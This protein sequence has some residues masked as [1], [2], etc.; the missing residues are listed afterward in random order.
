MIPLLTVRQPM[1]IT[2]RQ[3]KVFEAVARHQSFTKAAAALYLTQPAVSMQIK[4]LESIIGLPLFEQLGKRIYLTE[5]GRELYRYSRAIAAQLEEAK[6]VME[7]LKGIEQ[8]HLLVTVASTVN[9]FA[10]RLLAAFC[11]RYPGVRVNLDVTNRQGLLAQLDGNATDIVLMGRPPEGLALNAEP[12]MSNPLVVIAP[13]EHSLAD[14]QAIPLTRLKGETFLM[15]EPGSGTR[16][17]MERFF[18][19]KGIAL[20]SGMEMSSNE[21][22]KQS[23]E[24]GLGLGI[25]S[26]HTV[27]L[28]LEANRLITLDIECFPILRHWYVVHRQGKRLPR[29]ART[30]KDFVLSEAQRFV[31]TPTP[32]LAVGR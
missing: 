3:L 1:D 12:F 2:L 22:I 31:R 21:A 24:A 4:Q 10:A 28:E 26:I 15:R 8:G 19:D 18:S 29:V 32:L 5:A 27:E 11:R 13:P 6:Q 7:E 23:V 17:A 30:F 20:A 25:V 14:Q 16:I 9:Y